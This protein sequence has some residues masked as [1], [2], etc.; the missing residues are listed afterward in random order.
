[1]PDRFHKLIDGRHE[2]VEHRLLVYPQASSAYQ[3]DLPHLIRAES[4]Y[5]RSDGAAEGMADDVR[6]FQTHGFDE[7]Q[8][9]EGQV[10]EIVEM[11][12]ARGVAEAR[13]QRRDHAIAFGKGVQPGR[14]LPQT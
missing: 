4:R 7:V 12:E 6:A 5:L 1:M 9:V 13:V 10:D 14:P 3:D 2:E 8:V 11:L